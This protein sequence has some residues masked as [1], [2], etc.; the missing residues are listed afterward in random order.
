MILYLI[1]CW[2]SLIRFENNISCNEEGIVLWRWDD[3][4][5]NVPDLL[6]P[7]QLML[8][9]V[10]DAGSSV[11]KLLKVGDSFNPSH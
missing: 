4:V 7:I 3:D 9:I 6:V 5:W 1:A 10:I 11:L 2:T 8:D